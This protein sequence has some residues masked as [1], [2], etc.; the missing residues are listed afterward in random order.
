MKK[1]LI[2]AVIGGL[3]VAGAA[4]IYAADT[5]SGTS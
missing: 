3:I 5:S 2:A 1:A 4:V